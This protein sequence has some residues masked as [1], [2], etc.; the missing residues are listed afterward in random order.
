VADLLLVDNDARIADLVAFFLRRSGHAVRTVPSFAAARVEIARARPDLVLSDL[1]LGEERGLDELPRLSRAGLLP[2][3]LV[4][5]GY[6]DRAAQT[7]LERVPEVVGVLAKPFDLDVLVARV[8]AATEVHNVAPR[9]AAA[10]AGED[11][12]IELAREADAP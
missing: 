2:P 10:P 9:A 6:V 3:T 11:G 4:V 5:S 8:N 7:A 1:D 12:W